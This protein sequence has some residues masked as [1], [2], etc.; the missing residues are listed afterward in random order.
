M[1]LQFKGWIFVQ[2]IALTIGLSAIAHL[3]Q[4]FNQDFDPNL[5][6]EKVNTHS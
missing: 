2:A 6:I 3:D 5:S 4:P 1:R